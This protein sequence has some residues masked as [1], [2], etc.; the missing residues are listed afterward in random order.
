MG[1]SLQDRAVLRVVCV[2]HNVTFSGTGAWSE[3]NPNTSRRWAFKLDF[4]FNISEAEKL[5][6][7]GELKLFLAKKI[8]EGLK[9]VGLD[10]NE[11]L[12]SF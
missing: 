11:F 7:S 3:R 2:R 4:T 6:K 9:V 5:E 8:K 12:K 1:N 10:G